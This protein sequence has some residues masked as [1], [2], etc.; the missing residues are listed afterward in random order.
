MGE[1]MNRFSKYL[2]FMIALA[3]PGGA[4]ADVQCQ[5]SITNIWITPDGWVSGGF[6]GNGLPKGW[7]LCSV[8]G[9]TVVNDGYGSK[10]V[11]SDA[12]KSIYSLLLTL[13]VSNQPVTLQF[14][15]PADCSY[16]ALPPDGTPSPFPANFG[17]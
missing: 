12:C 3:C 17:R 15:G 2:M 1:M 16:A 13:K 4:W 6:A 8:A 14:H 11:S 7:W 5:L 10:T 9:S